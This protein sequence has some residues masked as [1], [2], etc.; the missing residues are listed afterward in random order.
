[1]MP[2]MPLIWVRLSSRTDTVLCGA[3]ADAAAKTHGKMMR[4]WQHVG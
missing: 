3:P 1:M 2:G 4:A